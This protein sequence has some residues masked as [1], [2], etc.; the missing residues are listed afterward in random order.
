MP[1]STK[2]LAR[3]GFEA[4]HQVVAARRQNFVLRDGNTQST[5][6][7]TNKKMVSNESWIPVLFIPFIAACFHSVVKCCGQLCPILGQK[8]KKTSFFNDFSRPQNKVKFDFNGHHWTPHS[9]KHGK[10]LYLLKFAKKKSNVPTL[11]G[12]PKSIALAGVGQTPAPGWRWASPSTGHVLRLAYI[13]DWACPIMCLGMFQ[14]WQAQLIAWAYP[15]GH[16]KQEDG[17]PKYVGR[18]SA[19]PPSTQPARVRVWQALSS[20]SPVRVK[21]MRNLDW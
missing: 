4:S 6:S 21:P 14:L 9:W 5:I 18:T 15:I 12:M 8:L 19:C 3:V 17:H 1:F 20:P 13:P 7:N 2:I 11:T 10:N 16:A